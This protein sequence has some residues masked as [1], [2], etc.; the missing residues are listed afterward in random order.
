MRKH[1][2]PVS[3]ALKRFGKSV[4]YLYEIQMSGDV[5]QSGGAL[6][7]GQYFRFFSCACSAF[8]S[9]SSFAATIR[10]FA[11]FLFVPVQFLIFIP[12]SVSVIDSGPDSGSGSGSDFG[13]GSRSRS[14]FIS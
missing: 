9:L 3:K 1:C 5:C 2:R 11:I 4:W 14:K 8:L 7:V 6:L 10:C 13:S 12:V